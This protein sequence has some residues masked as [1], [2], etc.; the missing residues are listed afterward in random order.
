MAH[1]ARREAYRTPQYTTTGQWAPYPLPSLS[2]V[3][4]V[5]HHSSER[6]CLLLEAYSWTTALITEIIF[7]ARTVYSWKQTVFALLSYSWET[8]NEASE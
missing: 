7:S 1:P 6:V 3:L 2:L 8:C 5:G 4:C